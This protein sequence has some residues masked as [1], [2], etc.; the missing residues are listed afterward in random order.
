MATSTGEPHTDEGDREDSESVAERVYWIEKTLVTGRPDREEGPYRLGTTLW[1]R[2][3]SRSGR[4]INSSMRQANLGDIVLHFT[5][6]RAITGISMV[7]DRVD[8]SFIGLPNT[9]WAGA[10][11]YRIQLS[12][13]VSLE[14]PL[15]RQD[16]FDN[17][18]AAGKLREMVQPG[19]GLFYN[20]NLELNQGAYLTRAPAELI[21]L[22]NNVYRNKTG[23]DLPYLD[24]EDP[25]D[26][27][28]LER[29]EIERIL[30]V[31]KT[32]KNLILQGPPGV[33]K[34]YA[35]KRLGF[36]I[37]G[38]KDSR[39]IGLI[40]F[41]QSY[42][43]EDFIQGY[44]PTASGE[45]ALREGRFV[46]FCNRAKESGQPFVFIIDEINR[47]N[48]S[49]IL[50]ELMLLIEGDKRGP[51]WKMPLAYDGDFYVPGN[52]FLLGLMNTADRSLAVVD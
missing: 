12:D 6:N 36:A 24:L 17:P 26:D 22:L 44:R 4:D 33:G 49:R 23:R 3:R 9:D 42:T 19:S 28:F 2:Q 32:K 7:A 29:D 37:L 1:S 14:P 30:S 43:Y 8:D 27:L 35:A 21:T 31:W 46:E 10:P 41:H 34:T 39:R 16:L 48:L 52:V 51:E 45:F 40:Q 20:K 18:D 13:F 50:G 38:A 15:Q 5:D 11:A 47:G 25:L